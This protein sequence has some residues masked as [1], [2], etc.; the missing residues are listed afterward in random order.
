N[1]DNDLEGAALEDVNEMEAVARTPDLQV[2]I[3]LDRASGYATTTPDWTDARVGIVQSDSNP[4]LISTPLTSWGERNMGDPQTLEDFINWGVATLPAEHYAVVLWDHGSGLYGSMMDT[5]SSYDMLTTEELA[6]ALEG[7]P[8]HIDVLGFDAC[9]MASS[10]IMYQVRNEVSYFVASEETEGW[11]GRDYTDL[12]RDLLAAP[13][14]SPQ[15]FAQVIVNSSSDDA[16]ITTLSAADATGPELAAAVAGF[17]NAVVATATSADWSAI[18]AA[19]DASAGFTYPEFRDLGSFMA[20]IVGGVPGAPIVNAANAVLDALAAKVVANFSLPAAGG[21]GL[22]I[23]LPDVGE[24]VMAGY[25]A[26]DFAAATGWDEFLAALTDR[27][28]RPQAV[29]DWAEPNDLRSTAYD[30]HTLSGPGNRYSA[31]SIHNAADVDWFRFD[32][33]LDGEAGSRVSIAFSNAAGN[34][35]LYLY[36]AQGTFLASSVTT[37]NTESVSLQGRPAGTYFARIAGQVNPSYTLGI[38]APGSQPDWLEDNNTRDKASPVPLNSRVVGLNIQPGD[39]DWFSFSPSKLPGVPVS[40]RVEFSPPGNLT[41]E[42]YDDA[43]NLLATDTGNSGTLSVSYPSGIHPV[44]YVRVLGQQG[45][46]IPYSL[47][48]REGQGAAPVYPLIATQVLPGGARVSF[49]DADPGDAAPYPIIA[50]STKDLAYRT[51][52]ADIL[53]RAGSGPAVSSI[54]LLDGVGSL[55]D[56]GIVV[57]GP[58]ASLGSLADSRRSPDEAIA[59]L[60]A[61]SGLRSVALRSGFAGANL[62]GFTTPGGWNLGNDIDGDGATND[63]AALLAGGGLGTFTAL[64][65]VDG[66]LFADGPVNRA[67]ITGG[68][69]NGDLASNNG[70]I[71]RLTVAAQL[72]RLTQTYAGGTIR[73]NVRSAGD[74]AQLTVTGGHVLGAVVSGGSIAKLTTRALLEPASQ[75]WRGG[76]VAGG[77]TAAWD[78]GTLTLTG[79]D[80][81][82]NVTVGGSTRSIY[83]R[84]LFNTAAGWTGGNVAD[85]RIEVGWALDSLRTDRDFTDSFVEA[86]LIGSVSVSGLISGTGGDDEIHA[87]DPWSEFSVADLTG[88]AWINSFFPA[89]FSGVTAWVG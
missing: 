61:S 70:G 9:L 27:T 66:D 29:R 24:R 1:G 5:R 89:D 36:D 79:G 8:T 18:E 54:T 68:D 53:V 67:T 50:W 69:L 81:T 63:P 82:G 51:R 22:T 44:Y 39:E 10:E 84:A 40:A 65:D 16:D 83:V 23:H 74:I 14:L 31:L 41:I 12:F 64:G 47:D 77:I 13:G 72:N 6:I 30:L 56:I 87:R 32:L 46:F 76:S 3:I 78:L 52:T 37:L 33:P 57:E 73:G 7:V 71:S 2:A 15:Q 75:T 43:G 19:R 35:D 21:T 48:V 11:D 62:N 88:S 26:L 38:D 45:A 17:V 49:Y 34:L 55:E 28:A 4:N 86:D 60:V 25:S 58:G 85:N 59:F 80:L 20:E 42:L